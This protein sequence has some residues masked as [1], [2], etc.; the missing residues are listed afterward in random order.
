VVAA[1]LVRITRLPWPAGGYAYVR[2]GPLWRK[3]GREPDLEVWRQAIRGLRAE[4]VLKRNLWLRLL[5]ML[6]DAD[7]RAFVSMLEQEGFSPVTSESRQRTMLVDLTP[8]L[9]QLRKGLDQKWRNC[10]NSGERSGLKIVEG[11]DDRLIEQFRVPFEEMVSRKGLSEPGDIRS[12]QAI[13]RE[14]PE[15]QKMRVFLAFSE[16]EVHAGAIASLLGE[17]GIYHFGATGSKGMKSKASYVLQW[18]IINWLK[19]RNCCMYD[20]HGVNPTKNPG[21]YHFKSGLCGRNGKEVAFV[22]SF[23]ACHGARARITAAAANIF[24]QR[25]TLLQGLLARLRPGSRIASSP[26]PGASRR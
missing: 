9:D 1:A 2:W 24:V 16:G 13:Q 26:A 5:P 19:E 18:R 4:Y 20:L 12:F 11:D 14:L 7:D 10:L 17:R 8:P 25:R 3:Q 6:T 21:G 23:D 15:H 22:G